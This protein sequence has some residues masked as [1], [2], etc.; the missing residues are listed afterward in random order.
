M[1]T[2]QTS[3]NIFTYY[4]MNNEDQLKTS[5]GRLGKNTSKNILQS[6]DEKKLFCKTKKSFHENIKS[7]SHLLPC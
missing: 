6:Q 3:K 7:P 4:I 1:S 5:H 2:E